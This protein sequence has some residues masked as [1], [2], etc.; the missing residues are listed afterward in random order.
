MGR[1]LDKKTVEASGELDPRVYLFREGIY[2]HAAED[3]GVVHVLMGQRRTRAA[4]EA[5]RASIR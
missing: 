2:L 1:S 3:D 5:G 4:V